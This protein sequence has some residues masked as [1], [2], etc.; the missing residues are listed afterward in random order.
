MRAFALPLLFVAVPGFAA[1]SWDAAREFEKKFK[2]PPARTSWAIAAHPPAPSAAKSLLDPP[3]PAMAEQEALLLGLELGLSDADYAP[4]RAQIAEL[5]AALAALR[6]D[7]P[8]LARVQDRRP[9]PKMVVLRLDEALTQV[10][11]QGTAEKE[12][13]G[14]N[15]EI[16]VPRSGYGPID[17]LA[18]R[19]GGRFSILRFEDDA[20]IALKSDRVLD[21]RRVAKEFKAI[22]GV[23]EALSE[24]DFDDE[25]A[26]PVSV[27]RAGS[28][29]RV[30]LQHDQESWFFV[31]RDQRARWMG[32]YRQQR[33]SKGPFVTGLMPPA[34]EE[35][36]KPKPVAV[37]PIK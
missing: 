31:V 2:T 30:T 5:Q 7:F 23:Q 37:P 1:E 18:E 22:K 20:L 29:W 35:R 27:E 24:A 4:D 36:L 12:A 21:L 13:P 15:G 14:R 32:Y 28:E 9:I 3:T 10:I 17:R 33:D 11:I 16:E 26:K 19:L 6:R 25:P 34:L 8:E